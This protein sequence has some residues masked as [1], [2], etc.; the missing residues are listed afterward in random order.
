YVVL[1]ASNGIEAMQ[2]FQNHH[3]RI[4]LLLT[5]VVMPQMG[6]KELVE[7]LRRSDP[8][9]KVIYI[10]GYSE[11]VMSHPL[12]PDGKSYLLEKPFTNARLLEVVRGVLD[13]VLTGEAS[14]PNASTP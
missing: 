12:Q 3:E 8:E 7:S 4:D 10:S 9:L 14:D 13:G 5:D 11:K 1:A 6:G 2:L